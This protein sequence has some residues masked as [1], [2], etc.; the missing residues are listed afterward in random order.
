MVR[1]SASPTVEQTLNDI[2][3]R[4]VS[5]YVA[6]SDM[7]ILYPILDDTNNTYA[8][9]IVPHDSDERP[10]WV[11]VM[12]RVVSD[13]VVIDEDGPADKTLS[14]ALMVNGG[15]PRE[16]IILAYRSESFPGASD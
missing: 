5:R 4:E 13:Y 7:D 12:A 8:V 14:E 1:V 9:V 16:K 10:S 2:T 3:R 15:V 6:T 11:F